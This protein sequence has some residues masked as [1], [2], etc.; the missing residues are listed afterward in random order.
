MLA[1]ILG[2]H[3]YADTLLELRN[4]NEVVGSYPGGICRLC[5]LYDKECGG[6]QAVIDCGTFNY[7]IEW[8][9]EP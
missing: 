7:L 4:G 8:K 9:P 5:F 3:I 6:S 1:E 2:L